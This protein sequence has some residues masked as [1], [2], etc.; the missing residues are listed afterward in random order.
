ML[1]PQHCYIFETRIDIVT[2]QESLAQLDSFLRSEK[3]HIVTTLNPEILL[4]AKRNKKY[5]SILNKADLNVPDGTGL[6]WLLRALGAQDQKPVT[7]ADLVLRL[8]FKAQKNGLRVAI[9]HR[10]DGLST[11]GGLLQTIKKLYPQLMFFVIETS[12]KE[13]EQESTLRAIK[14]HE[15]HIIITD[16]GAPVQEA[17][18]LTH[19]TYFPS[20]RIG[21]G[22]G[23]ALDYITGKQKRAPKALRKLGLEWLWRLLQQP[24]RLPR[25]Y[26]AVV[27]FGVQTVRLYWQSKRI[28][29]QN[30]LGVIQRSDKKVLLVSRAKDPTHWQFPQGGIDSD[31]TP[32]EGVLRELREELGCATF[33]IEG[34]ADQTYQ[35]DWPKDQVQTF[36]GQEQYIFFLQFHGL[37][38]DF[39]LEEKELGAY[40]WV[41]PLEIPDTVHPVRREVGEYILSEMK[42][43]KLVK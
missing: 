11:K 25:I 30:A 13:A 14:R 33:S 3:A 24:K 1:R 40:K 26:R 18:L 2:F 10:A 41:D 22:V 29:R 35:Y 23:G 12:K 27:V 9:L 20:L 28:Y 19:K 6:A 16:F 32:E 4:E 37:D 42:R 7:G 43:F 21:I 5:R 31:E 39:H 38:K 17:W 36:R 8:L 15:P 34:K